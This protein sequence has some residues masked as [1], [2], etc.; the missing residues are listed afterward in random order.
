MKVVLLQDVAKI[1]RK[2]A[3]VEVPDGYAQNQ[4]IPRRQAKPATPENLKAALKDAADK[5]S[6]ADTA[7]AK[8]ERT[9]EALKD[10]KIVLQAPTKNQQGHLFAAVTK[11]QV[12]S[13]L[14]QVGIIADPAMVEVP[15]HIK[16]VGEHEIGLVCGS[17][18]SRFIIK[19]E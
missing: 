3:V 18:E 10:K 17:H 9:K 5:K 16:E 2:H 7:L 12:M 13:A 19:I 11:G 8:Y 4:L 1:G 6:A 15:G 14:N